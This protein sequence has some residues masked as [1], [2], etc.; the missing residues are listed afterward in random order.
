M[1]IEAVPQRLVKM[2]VGVHATVTQGASARQR[3]L[4]PNM[5]LP[6]MGVLSAVDACGVAYLR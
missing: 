2:A 3:C 1:R 5:S 4:A 6:D